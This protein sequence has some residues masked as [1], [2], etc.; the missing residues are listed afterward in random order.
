M[1]SA[2]VAARLN[3]S[4]ETVHRMCRSRKWPHVKVGRLYRFTEANYQAIITPVPPPEQNSRTQR[5]RIDRLLNAINQTDA[6]RS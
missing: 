5:Q 4:T 2:E 3:V 6:K 1:T